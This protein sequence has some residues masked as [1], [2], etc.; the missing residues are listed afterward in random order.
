MVWGFLFANLWK[1]IY[2]TLMIRLNKYLASCGIGS[3]RTCDQYIFEKK[4]KVNGQVVE[5]VGRVID[6]RKDIVEFEG[7]QLTYISGFTYLK[8]NKPKGYI[9]SMKDDRGR[10][11]VY[12]L[13]KNEERVFS[14]G[15]LDYDTEG[16]LLFTNDG[17]LAEKIAHPRNEIKKV[18]IAKIEGTIKESEL[19]VLRNGV[20]IDGERLPSAKVEFVSAAPG[21]TKIRITIRQGINHQIKKMISAIGKNLLFLKRVQVG[22][23]KLGGLARGEVK[24]LSQDEIQSLKSLWGKNGFV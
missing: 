19:A 24:P 15:R 7:K 2:N 1:N 20:V 10:K 14:I 17:Q 23:I 13:L 8:M 6:E 9:C 12:D 16:L 3:R 5:G 18:Y 4:V 11:C 21:S 22:E